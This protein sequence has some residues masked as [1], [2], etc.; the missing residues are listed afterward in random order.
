MAAV[1]HSESVFDTK[2]ESVLTEHGV[3]AREQLGARR[4]ALMLRAMSGSDRRWVLSQLSSVQQSLVAPSLDELESMDLPVPSQF[5]S[6]SFAQQQPLNVHNSRHCLMLADVNDVVELLRGEPFALIQHVLALGSWPWADAVLL[7]TGQ[8]NRNMEQWTSGRSSAHSLDQALLDQLA[9]RLP[10]PQSA[11]KTQSL[12]ARCMGW[13]AGRL[14]LTI[15]R[16]VGRPE[17]ILSNSNAR[18]V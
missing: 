12:M 14:G 4:A 10:V 2:F 11:P 16:G 17:F 3:F 5:R 15:G 6:P 18:S 9:K 1:L 7:A 13:L 8:Q